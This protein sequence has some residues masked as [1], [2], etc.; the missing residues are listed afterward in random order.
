MNCGA[1]SYLHNRPKQNHLFWFVWFVYTLYVTI[2]CVLVAPCIGAQCY[3]DSY[4][5]TCLA[6]DSLPLNLWLLKI[7]MLSCHSLQGGWTCYG[8]RCFCFCS[9]PKYW[10]I[11][12]RKQ[13]K[14][15]TVLQ[16]LHVW[17]LNLLA[18]VARQ[19]TSR[20]PVP[21]VRSSCVFTTKQ[22]APGISG[23]WVEI[24]STWRPH[25]SLTVCTCLNEPRQ[26]GKQS[27]LESSVFPLIQE[28]KWP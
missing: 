18:A 20:L 10:R 7:R 17:Q 28:Q 21:A 3:D 16:K 13:K 24:A 23:D 5:T 25:L 26:I 6:R 8:F 12:R 4:T 19:R 1:I 9:S 27:S 22:T 11:N 15:C 2:P 14:L